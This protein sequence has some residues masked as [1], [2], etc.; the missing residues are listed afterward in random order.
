MGRATP[1]FNGIDRDKRDMK[2][3]KCVSLKNIVTL[4]EW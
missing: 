2:Y 4:F 1:V 3:K